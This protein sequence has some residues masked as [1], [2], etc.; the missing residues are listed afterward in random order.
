M[1]HNILSGVVIFC[2]FGIVLMIWC[3]WGESET[4][5]QNNIEINQGEMYEIDKEVFKP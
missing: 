1:K 2:V 3:L 4:P 5:I